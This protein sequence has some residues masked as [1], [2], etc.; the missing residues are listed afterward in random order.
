M[1]HGVGGMKVLVK[2]KRYL[3]KI[4]VRT[5]RGTLKSHQ[6]ICYGLDNIADVHRHVTAKQLHKFFPDVSLSELVRPKE[7]HLLISHM[8]GQLAPQ[9]IRAV[10]DLVLWDGPLG[11]TVA[12]THPELFEEIAFSAH[13][14]RTHFARSM[15]TAA[16]KYEE[17]T[18]INPI[19]PPSQQASL[20]IQHQQFISAATTRDFLEW[21]RWDSIGAA[22]EPRCGGC[23]C[24]NCLPGGKEMTLAE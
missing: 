21:W 3:L 13:M 10:G 2:T 15:R 24:G 11:K 1:V 4:R 22:C 16:E 23:R 5:S 18:C 12:G 9:K 19:H 7:I 8:E 20:T 6:L 14:S 17:L